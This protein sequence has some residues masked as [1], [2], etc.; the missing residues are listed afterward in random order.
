MQ[1]KVNQSQALGFAGHIAKGAHSY[2]NTMSGIATDDV[3][4]GGFVQTTDK[5]GEVRGTSAGIN[6]KILGLAIFTH[7]KDGAGDSDVIAK[8][9]NVTILNAGSAYIAT[10]LKANVGQYVLIKQADGAVVFDDSSIKEGH[11]FS[12]FVVAKGND[13]AEAGI[14]EITTAHA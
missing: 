2:F 6:G 10:S 13:S 12:G 5:N 3:K 7:F 14:I 11:T 1:T 9:D 4:V 8:G